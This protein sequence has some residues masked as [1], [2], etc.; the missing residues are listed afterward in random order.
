MG[1]GSSVMGTGSSVM[2]AGSFVT[3]TFVEGRRSH[4][5]T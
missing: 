4:A 5:R 3:D 2:G 1:T